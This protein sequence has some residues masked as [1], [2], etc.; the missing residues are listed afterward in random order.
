MPYLSF[1]IRHPIH[2]RPPLSGRCRH[3]GV[4]VRPVCKRNIAIVGTHQ[5]TC[6]SGSQ[7]HGTPVHV[8]PITSSLSSVLSRC[9]VIV[10]PHHCCHHHHHRNRTANW[11]SPGMTMSSCVVCIGQRH[12]ALVVRRHVC[13][14][15]D[16]TLVSV[17]GTW[18]KWA[19]TCARWWVHHQPSFPP[20]LSPVVSVVLVIVIVQVQV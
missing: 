16:A 15:T 17:G 6:L 19:R 10:R 18:R 5:M 11:P 9:R 3:Q 14:C 13:C 4:Y 7:R 2:P 20:P 1:V 8:V 12:A